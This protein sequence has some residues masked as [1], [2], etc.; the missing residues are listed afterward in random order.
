MARRDG[1]TAVAGEWYYDGHWVEFYDIDTKI[2]PVQVFSDSGNFCIIPGVA[3]QALKLG[4]TS[5]QMNLEFAVAS[6]IQTTGGSAITLGKS[7][8]SFN[9]NVSGVT[10]NASKLTGT[11]STTGITL[12]L[13]DVASPT[14]ANATGG[15]LKL[16]GDTD[17]LFQWDSTN[18]NWGS[19][20]HINLGTGLNYK[21]NNFS[22]LSATTL[23]SGVLASSLTSV[24]VLTTL[25]VD[26][27]TIYV[28]S[29]NHRL[30]VCTSTPTN[31]LEVGSNTGGGNFRLNSTLGA[32]IAP[33]LQGTSW[34][35][36]DGWTANGTTL[37]RVPGS[38][39]GTATQIVGTPPSIGTVYKI[40]V[41]LS[42]VSGSILW[43]YGGSSGSVFS[44]AQTYTNYITALSTAGFI[45]TANGASATCT[46]TAITIQ[47]LTAATGNLVVER[48]ATINGNL[49][50]GLSS[51]AYAIDVWANPGTNGIVANLTGGATTGSLVSFSRGAQY[52]WVA[53]IG[54]GATTTSGIPNSYFGISDNGTAPKFVMAYTTG[55]IGLGGVT[56]PTNLVSLIGTAAQTIWMERNTTA[57]TAGQGLTISS[58]GAK[59]GGTDLAGGD[60]T[61]QSGI[62]TGAGSS[63]IHLFTAT[64]RAAGPTD[65]AQTEK[66]TILG[67]GNVGIGTTAPTDKFVVNL[68]SS[69]TTNTRGITLGS[70]SAYQD[71]SLGAANDRGDNHYDLTFNTEYGSG[72]WSE[73]MRITNQGNV[74]IGT[75]TPS[76][77]LHV[78][79]TGLATGSYLC[80]AD[81]SVNSITG[82]LF[83]DTSTDNRGMISGRS[84]IGSTGNTA[85]FFLQLGNYNGSSGDQGWITEMVIEKDSGSNIIAPTQWKGWKYIY[86]NGT[87]Y[88]TPLVITNAGN[89]GIGTTGP[90]AGLEI[91]N[92]GTALKLSYDASNY[93]TFSVSSVGFCTV[94]ATGSGVG[95]G[96]NK[97]LQANYTG[98]SN[99]IR[100]AGDIYFN[101]SGYGLTNAAGDIKIAP[102]GNTYFSTGNVGIGLTSSINQTLTLKDASTFGSSTATADFNGIG[103]LATINGSAN[104]SSL[105]L[106]NLTVRGTMSVYELLVQQIR[107]TNGSVSISSTGKVISETGTGPYVLTM[108]VNTYQYFMAGD[109]IRAKR[110]QGSNTYDSWCS[111]TSV[112]AGSIGTTA[113]T[114]TVTVLGGSAAPA[115]GYEYVRMG[116]STDT[117]RQG[118]IYMTADDSG[119]PFID[120]IDGVTAY[121]AFGTYATTK[122]RLG[123]LT[124]IVSP[125]M[126]ALSGYG[127]YTQNAYL[128]GN[129]NIVGTLSV[130]DSKFY[131]GPIARNLCGN[132]EQQD[133]ADGA[134]GALSSWG[135]DACT[136]LMD[137]ST[138]AVGS[139]G[140]G[141]HCINITCSSHGSGGGC[142]FPNLGITLLGGQTYTMSC[143][144]KSPTLTSVNNLFYLNNT[145]GYGPTGWV[146]T[147]SWQRFT[148]TFTVATTRTFSVGF[149]IYAVGTIYIDGLQIESGSYV[150]PY[151]RTDGTVLSGLGTNLLTGDNTT[152]TSSIGSWANY[153]GGVAVFETDHMKLTTAA[154]GIS[155]AV[156]AGI[157][158]VA[159]KQYYYSCQVK[160]QSGAGGITLRLSDGGS[161]ELTFTPTG[162]QQTFGGFINIATGNTSLYIYTTSSNGSIY[163]IDNVIVQQVTNQ[164]YGV[165]FVRGG[166]GGTM[167][168]PVVG[169]SDYGLSVVPL[170]GALSPNPVNA[171]GTYI[172]NYS[173]SGHQAVLINAGGITG[174]TGS[175]TVTNFSLPTTG[176]AQIAGWSFDNV[177]IYNATGTVDGTDYT[178]TGI[179][180]SSTG[181][182]AAPKFLLKVDGS[183]KFK[184]D[185]SGA[186]GTFTGSI[187]GATGTIGGWT[188]GTADLH[189]GKTSLTDAINAGVWVGNNGISLGGASVVPPFS[190][191][192]AGVLT[193]TS[194]SIA[195]WS[196]DATAGITDN[197]TEASAN[198]LF[199]TTPYYLDL[200]THNP[201]L[202][203]T[204]K[205]GYNSVATSGSSYVWTSGTGANQVTLTNGGSQIGGGISGTTTGDTYTG[206][207]YPHKLMLMD[208]SCGTN[209]NTLIA[210]DAS[211]TYTVSCLAQY[212]GYSWG[213]AIVLMFY[214]GSTYI[215]NSDIV[216]SGNG[217]N[218]NSVTTELFSKI[219][220]TPTGTTGVRAWFSSAGPQGIGANVIS[221]DITTPKPVVELS[222][223]GFLLWTAPAQYIS[224]T[225]AGGI[226]IVGGNISSSAISGSSI[227]G[228]DLTIGSGTTSAKLNVS[229]I[230]L[231][232]T[233]SFSSA[234]FSVTMAGVFKATTGSF[235]GDVKVGGG[236]TL[237]GASTGTISV[238]SGLTLSG[239][240]TGT[241]TGGTIQTASS[242][243]N[244]VELSGTS[245]FLKNSSDKTMY[246]I[247]NSGNNVT[248]NLN[249][250]N[251]FLGDIIKNIIATTGGVIEFIKLGYDLSSLTTRAKFFNFDEV[252]FNALSY[253]YFGSS[254]D[255]SCN[256]TTGD[257]NLYRSAASTL[258]T[259]GNLIIGKQYSGI[260]YTVT[261]TDSHT[262]TIDWNNGNVQQVT[263]NTT[264]AVTIN[265]N[266][267]SHALSGGR[268]ILYIRNSGSTA[269]S[270]YT[271]SPA[272]LWP[273]NG[274]T[275]PTPA[276]KNTGTARHYDVFSFIYDGSSF[277]GNVASDYSYVY[278]V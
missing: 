130:N 122:A 165:W 53:G 92:T 271:F 100:S 78:A 253:L 246:T 22:V 191:T 204:R 196:I 268:Y 86:H 118:L 247:S 103:F 96:F 264:G 98:G 137:V 49:G 26:T 61:L 240:S 202:R 163:E 9:L 150:T 72:N 219:I 89:V 222:P 60:L 120:V 233:T 141:R 159:G 65:R 245:L 260:L 167:Q 231:G 135:G 266:D 227:I 143:W 94:N 16:K 192:S 205:F 226:S 171:S 199:R 5:Y 71:L 146:L 73:R 14:N 265:L 162:T 52:K 79:S 212:A 194:G 229:G 209:N 170:I 207:S 117:S 254:T 244:R 114:A 186:S 3:A 55:N 197:V 270:S 248:E 262:A 178:S 179:V 20:E 115:A 223:S 237:G 106:D 155:G 112:T 203:T 104:T 152:F 272:V 13:N 38:G 147:P 93:V 225:T 85:S 127:L 99:A 58:G 105:I 173:V 83:V 189:N 57:A 134:T 242:G 56:S 234:S 236:I 11:V 224:M 259:D 90:G 221:F 39:G 107:A 180:L 91:L 182:I 175:T 87:T 230:Y 28:D 210:L 30:G 258:K 67:S 250:S 1:A 4:Y 43:I 164:D 243:N 116:S 34:T 198:L 144:A 74:G 95:F 47:A 274:S 142:Y 184:G 148:Y 88:V 276:A 188:I 168:N 109:I 214:N 69:V 82:M 157:T 218:T 181:Y 200:T 80:R 62:S 77:L 12:T 66:M 252:H 33:D 160:L 119:A 63:A 216:I 139:V 27:N 24:G 133:K 123:K 64:A 145:E 215:D 206:S 29:T 7:G 59:T 32:N 15:G 111:V 101:T 273:G 261:P 267:S 41:T 169:F 54:G 17:K 149:F 124:G 235:T 161:P 131:A 18:S 177:K 151:Q 121:T 256:I 84:N 40:T 172:G 2:N 257:T 174:Y 128:E 125:T 8:D 208:E 263:F 42:A 187:T 37:A 19:S 211:T 166:A 70:D 129:A 228:G 140:A 108:G 48:S 45:F 25:A 21:I 10:Y 6:T 213:V 113:P 183:A 156:L 50:L 126:G 132:S 35:C 238:G 23:G 68:G 51:P 241:I 31:M 81:V 201:N 255:G 278:G 110:Y 76:S 239:A 185:I 249:V 195:G 36:T 217:S 136:Y 275:A 277:S 190:V 46:I 153:S 154:S 251:V 102:V 193:A 220:T 97:Q 44:S 138:V 269:P 158:Q 75:T 176:T 232:D